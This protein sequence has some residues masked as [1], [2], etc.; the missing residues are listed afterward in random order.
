MALLPE[1]IPIIRD[2][3]ADFK[4]HPAALAAF[5]E[6][7]SGG[8][9]FAN[10]KILIQFE[11]H[12]FKKYAADDYQRYT[13]GKSTY[14]NE[15]R[16]VLNN[17]VSVQSAEW[18]AFNAA[19]KI[20]PYAAMMAT[21]IGMGQIMGF[22]YK[23]LGYVSVGLM[24]DAAKSGYKA[25]VWQIAKFIQTDSTLYQALKTGDWHTVAVRYNGAG[26]KALAARL[27]RE[28]YNI[29]MAKA[30]GKY[31]ALLT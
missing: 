23:R 27:G 10:G 2:V 29:S 30:Y 26:Y 17:K 1:I 12:H 19:W 24:W 14:P 3:A 21:S 22:H 18:I 7:E 4:L 5:I 31:K 11:P 9:G 16:T 13:A 8:K 28:P 6:V 15:W 25:Q 20:L